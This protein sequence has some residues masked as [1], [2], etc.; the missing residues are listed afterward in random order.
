MNF[1]SKSYVPYSE[2]P[3]L[4]EIVW[5]EVYIS[6]DLWKSSEWCMAEVVK[7]HPDY[8]RAEV[9]LVGGGICC[10]LLHINSMY[11]REVK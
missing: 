11:R 1:S 5:V 8:N 6:G 7:V 2:L 3:K 9:V 10:Q 4:G